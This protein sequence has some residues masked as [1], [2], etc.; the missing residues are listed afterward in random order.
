MGVQT[1]RAALLPAGHRAP[2]SPPG[3]DA[4]RT[5]PAD[6]VNVPI[7]QHMA[8]LRRKGAK[9]G[10]GKDPERAAVHAALSRRHRNVAAVSDLYELQLSLDLPNSLPAADL[11]LLRWHL[12]EGGGEP[13]APDSYP[14]LSARGPAARI[15]GTLVGDLARSE[16]GWALT[17]RQEVHPDEF[18]QLRELVE[19]LA[20]RTST[21]GTIGY[22]RFLQHDIPDV[23]IADPAAGTTQRLS[24]SPGRSTETQLIP[25]P[26]S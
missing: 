12:G 26:W 3:Q 7:G 17:A 14:L 5:N 1:R 13:Q 2:L 19:W 18:D 24:L 10:L 21:F 6:G 16:R 23:L 22:L 9:N 15:G 20:R 4:V 11:A 25:D 8:N